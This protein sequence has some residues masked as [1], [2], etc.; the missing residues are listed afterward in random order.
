MDDLRPAGLDAESRSIKAACPGILNVE[1]KIVQTLERDEFE[2]FVSV[3]K[4][5]FQNF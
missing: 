3:S 2:N 1:A 5:D 4:P